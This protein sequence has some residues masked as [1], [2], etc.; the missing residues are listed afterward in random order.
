LSGKI[1]DHQTIAKTLE[2][3]TALHGWH[4]IAGIILNFRISA[5]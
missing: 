2:N 3:E 5:G 1:Y 4:N